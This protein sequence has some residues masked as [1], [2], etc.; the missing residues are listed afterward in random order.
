MSTAH[1]EALAELR[2][3]VAGA[4]PDAPPQHALVLGDEGVG[5]STLLRALAE[6]IRADEALATSWLPVPLDASPYNIGDVTDLWLNALRAAA[7]AADA[8]ALAAQAT[9]LERAHEGDALEEAARNALV[10]A[11]ARTQRRLLLLVD[12]L[13]AVLDRVGDDARLAHL[14]GVL[15]HTP[16][17]MWIGASTRPLEVAFDYRRPLYDQLRV[18]ALDPL[19]LAASR[20]LLDALSARDPKGT[21]H[22]ADPVRLTLLAPVLDGNPRALTRL[23][24][25][26]RGGAADTTT[27]LRVLLHAYTDLHRERV[28]R[29]GPQTQRVLDGLALRWEAATAEEIADALRLDRAPVSAQLSRLMERGFVD[30]VDVGQR[31][32]GY[33]LRDRRLALWLMA[34]A[35]SRGGQRA[36]WLGAWIDLLADDPAW[37]E[38]AEH[39]PPDACDAPRDAA[40]LATIAAAWARVG[41]GDPIR[42][43]RE[44]ADG[45]AADALLPLRDA[46]GDDADVIGLPSERRVLRLALR[47]SLA[48]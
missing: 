30:R 2:A 20:A 31:A 10:A 17:L 47:A 14:R 19:D 4:P 34:R 3:L 27:A 39:A 9:E 28:E 35:P 38:G 21:P 26:W 45:P 5:K 41:R 42:V 33:Q 12:D 15:Q 29:L 43:R 6:T 22:P 32:V 23:H 48:R 1:P 7:R 13:D 25:A 24:D 37:P 40:S 8:P 44:L 46:L 36:A 18:V 16:A 11:P